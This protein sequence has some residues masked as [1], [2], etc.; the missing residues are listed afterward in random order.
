MGA[1]TGKGIYARS[2]FLYPEDSPGVYAAAMEC[3]FVVFLDNVADEAI[4]DA[5][6]LGLQTYLYAMPAD[7]TPKNWQRTLY[8]EVDRVQ[9]LG[10]QGL[11]A[12]P[13]GGWRGAPREAAE[14]GAALASASR[15]LPS[16]GITSYPSWGYIETVAAEAARAGVWGSPQLYGIISPASSNKALLARGEKWKGIFQEVTPSLAAWARDSADQAEYLDTFYDERGAIL[17]Q[18]TSLQS[19][20]RIL[21]DIGSQRFEVLRY[22]NVRYPYGRSFIRAGEPSVARVLARRLLRPLDVRRG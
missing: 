12:D 8:T 17:W 5:Q 20:G 9:R 7:W 15:M 6:R 4:V 1:P 10:M 13:E 19:G 16:V 22:W 2:R 11:I 18:S 3:Q 14:L 21:P